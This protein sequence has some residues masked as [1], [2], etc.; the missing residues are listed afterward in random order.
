M[1]GYDEPSHI[2]MLDFNLKKN[3]LPVYMK[4][5]TRYRDSYLTTEIKVQDCR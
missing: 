4:W 5:A 1:T 3:V 2:K